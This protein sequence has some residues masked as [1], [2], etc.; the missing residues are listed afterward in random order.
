MPRVVTIP[1]WRRF[2]VAF[3]SLVLCAL[4]FHGQIADA[5]VSRG[6]SFLQGGR[7][8]RAER[9]YRR[10]LWWDPRST[11]AADRFAFVGFELRTRA[12]LDAAIEIAGDAL[13][14][15][16]ADQ[17]LLLDRALCLQAEGRYGEAR[18]DFARAALIRRD[19]QVLHFAGWAALRSGDAR[20]ARRYWQDALRIDP[21]FTPATLALRKVVTP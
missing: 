8:A 11:I 12:S 17:P 1:L 21:S 20:A 18:A 14:R 19:P 6:D 13:A 2:A 10:A 4:L 5:L 9:Y 7:P 15:T 16:P 3:V